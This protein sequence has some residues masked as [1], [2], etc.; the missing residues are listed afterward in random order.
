MMANG[1]SVE[2]PFFMYN[3]TPN[4]VTGGAGY[5]IQKISTSPPHDREV[6]AR[7]LEVQLSISH[8]L[9]TDQQ[10]GAEV[11]EWALCHPRHVRLKSVLCV[12]HSRTNTHFPASHRQA[13]RN[14]GNQ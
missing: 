8:C 10:L 12:W 6:C 3:Y 14:S 13:D 4:Y 7:T 5:K 2:L 1:S 9:Q 11:A